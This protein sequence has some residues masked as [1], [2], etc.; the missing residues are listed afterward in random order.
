MVVVHPTIGIP[1]KYMINVYINSANVTI[2]I[3]T[4]NPILILHPAFVYSAR[5]SM[6]RDI[7][8]LWLLLIFPSK[9]SE[10]IF[11]PEAAYAAFL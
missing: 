5:L 11:K 6:A 9:E 2:I 8:D 7:L 3:K 4:V 1:I 10:L